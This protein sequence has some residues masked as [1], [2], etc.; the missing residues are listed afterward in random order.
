MPLHDPHTLAATLMSARFYGA[1]SE[2]IDEVTVLREV[3]CG[4]FHWLIVN[5]RHG[6]TQDLYQL[7]VNDAGE[8]V[9][10][11]P[12][13]AAAYREAIGDIAEIS[14]D[15]G[16]TGNP[17][18]FKGEQSNTSVVF[19][20]RMYK[21]FRRLEHGLNPDVELLSEI[22]DCPHVAAVHGHTSYDLDGVKV[23][24]SMVQDLVPGATDGWKYALAL[25]GNP[26]AFVSEARALGAATARVHADLAAAFD[27]ESTPA[28][29]LAQRLRGHFSSLKK[30]APELSEVE[31]AV[32]GVYA[33][34]ASRGESVNLQ[35]IHGDLH[36]G[37]V[38]RSENG[39]TLVDFEG[40]PARDLEDRRRPDAAAR[41]VAGLVRSIDYAAHLNNGGSPT[42]ES[43]EWAAGAIGA[44]LEGYGYDTRDAF[45]ALL[46]R[47]LV[48]DKACYELVY[49]ANNRPDWIDIPRSAIRRLTAEG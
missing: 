25:T 16:V 15:T 36:L 42:A 24:L 39:Y 30:R 26:A 46:L 22:T 9:L 12:E 19:G 37:Q 14:G 18:P 49:E 29:Q 41:D 43:E 48:L 23:T 2:P 8:D 40:E 4:P 17:R 5:V 38:L 45:Q 1:K 20:G 34:L 33:A 10:G 6:E 31:E 11:T 47:A 35:R 13:G 3:P 44:L 7:L 32:M 21:V 28:R 27:T